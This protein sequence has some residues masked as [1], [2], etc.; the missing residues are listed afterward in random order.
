MLDV[1]VGIL[2]RMGVFGG[3]YG[4]NGRIF[5]LRVWFL[6]VWSGSILIEGGC[7]WSGSGGFRVE[8][9]WI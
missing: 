4:R 8:V 3:K 5:L 9:G 1:Q 6:C 2:Y 7:F